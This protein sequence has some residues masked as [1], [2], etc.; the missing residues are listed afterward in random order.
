MASQTATAEEVAQVQ[1]QLVASSNK[2]EASIA[3]LQVAV[4]PVAEPS[5]TVEEKNS[6]LASVGKVPE[7]S[8]ESASGATITSPRESTAKAEESA[9]TRPETSPA[10]DNAK[11]ETALTSEAEEVTYTVNYI[12]QDTREVVLSKTRTA[13][14]KP[15]DAS[16][17]VS[18][19]GK[20]I[21]NEPALHD[22]WY[23]RGD[24]L[25]RRA[26]ISRGGTATITYEMSF[27]PQ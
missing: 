10:T 12:D 26:I 11:P 20:E 17:A 14:I 27:L 4:K 2:L 13:I 25:E 24:S 9:T 15:G 6:E 7:V 3:G 19:N 23:A 16:V 5:V 8:N 22:Y 1:A 21:S 18:E